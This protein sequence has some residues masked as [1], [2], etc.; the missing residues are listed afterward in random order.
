MSLE[1]GHD[2]RDF[3]LV[4]FGGAGPQHACELAA[5]MAIPR[6][7]VPPYPGALSAL[8]IAVAGRREGTISRTVMVR[9]EAGM[10]RLEAAFQ[11]LE[12]QGRAEMAREGFP[13]EG[14]QLHH[15]LDVRYR[16]QSFELPVGRPRASEGRWRRSPARS[17]RLTKQRF[18][19]QDAAAPVEVVNVRLSVVAP[20]ER[21][22]LTEESAIPGEALW[23]DER[24]I[25]FEG[26]PLAR[27]GVRAGGFAARPLVP[28]ASARVAD[29]CDPPCLPRGLGSGGG[30]VSEPGAHPSGITMAVGRCVARGVPEPVLLRSGRDGGGAGTDRVLR[31][32]EGAPRLFLRGVS[33]RRGP[34]SR[35]LPTFRCTWGR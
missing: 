10:A 16:G 32:Y 13:A 31:Q 25:W 4:A 9:D 11:A 7:L 19:Y 26:G 15:G 24:P 33:T 12:A 3:T 28:R 20:T 17:I 2:P 14:L 8:G 34:W 27:Q 22:P 30:R 29:G 21:P 35:R 5:A 18:G 23:A 6:V 1:R